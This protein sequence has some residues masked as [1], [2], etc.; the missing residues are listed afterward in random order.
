MIKVENLT[1]TYNNGKGIFDV[2]F[3]VKEG[4]VIGYLGP[5]G[6]GKT[7]SIRALLGFMKQDSGTVQING[8]D[9]YLNAPK[10][11][12]FVGYLPGEI[13]FPDGMK[14]EEFLKHV[15]EMRGLKDKTRM[16]ELIER[17]ELDIKGEIKK[18]SKGM[19]Q[20]LG[21]VVAFM[22]D[23]KVLILD[24]PTS[25]LDPLMQNKFVE[26]IKEEKKR[27]KTIF[28][29]THIFE[30]AERT[31]DEVLIIKEGRIVVKAGVQELKTQQRKAFIV[32]AENKSSLKKLGFEL[33]QETDNGVEVFVSGGE[34]DDFIKKLS[35]VK[36]IN[37]EQKK[38]S[39][40]D[41][42]LTY[43]SKGETK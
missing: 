26:L 38:Q 11:M 30:E 24:E 39:L 42:F 40:E 8:L 14:G 19:K 21:I 16:H 37:L 22:H 5:N 17:F 23:P 35:T 6:S 7:T 13:S 4:Q 29:S 33:G 36:V 1:L 34:I 9:A 28:M 2:S 15:M 18:Y 10:I 31:C 12:E 3:S 20:K 32:Q 25:G 27:G 41:I 43:Y